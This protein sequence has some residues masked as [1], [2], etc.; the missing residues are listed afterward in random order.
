MVDRKRRLDC[1]N[2]IRKADIVLK[3]GKV[4]N[5][6]TEEILEADVAI[7]GDTIVG[8]GSYEGEREIDCTGKYLV[9]GFLDAHMHIE[10]SMV[11][12]GELTKVLV[13][14][15]TTTIVA[16]P[17]E[18]VNVCGVKGMDY[19]LKCAGKALVHIFFMIPSS[20]PATDVET[21]GC[22]EFLASDM[23]KYVDDARVLGLGETMRFVECY[24][25]ER[26]MS[27]K[28]ELFAKKHID[29]H[30]PGIT[31]KAVQAYRLA[32]VEN[33]HE[34]A[35]SEEVLDKLRAGFH[36]YIREGSG[37]KNLETLIRTLLDANVTMRGKSSM[38]S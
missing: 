17:H 23:M 15:G 24:Q 37:A 32:G 19:F 14:A 22:G 34:C 27:D 16:D 6:F 36:I 30:A 25:G 31:G 2:G 18:I 38:S 21:N 11:S 29:G 12:P 33:D 26:R 28:L 9:P 20:V 13:Q 5:V 8:V 7:C 35:N 1:A 10:S 4:L 3:H